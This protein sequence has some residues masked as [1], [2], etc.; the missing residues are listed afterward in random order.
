MANGSTLDLKII[1]QWTIY[2]FARK[3]VHFDLK[4]LK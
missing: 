4:Q 2:V 1:F 3:A